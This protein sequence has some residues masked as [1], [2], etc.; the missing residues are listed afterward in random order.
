MVKGWKQHEHS[1]NAELNK[2]G[3]EMQHSEDIK[4]TNIDLYLLVWKK[5]AYNIFLRKE[6]W[7]QQNL[8]SP[9]SLKLCVCV[10]V[11]I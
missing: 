5:N 7:I 10:H 1:V 11:Y 8:C 4:N 9:I 2:W 6:G 3:H